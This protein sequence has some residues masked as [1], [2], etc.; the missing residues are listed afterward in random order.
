MSAAIRATGL[1]KHYGAVA[2]VDGLDLEVER[3]EIYGFLGRNGAGKS[4]TIRM[5]LGM[6]SPTAGRVEVLGEPV[7]A[8]GP[9]LWRR[10]GHLVESAT[11][12]GELSVR[13]NLEVARRLQGLTD[14]RR[15][16]VVIEQLALAP[17]ADRPAAKLSLG[18]VQRLALARALLHAPELLILDEPA[19]GLDPAGVVEVR[20]LL[21][22][23][24]RDH[25]VTVF[26]SSHHLTE[27]ERVA[28][29]VGVVHAGRM[30]MEVDAA[31]LHALRER[32]LEVGSRD[33]GAAA[34]ALVGLGLAPRRVGDV[35]ELREPRALDA[36]E[37][38]ARALVA[39]G[40]PPTRLVVVE[41][42]LEAHFLRLTEPRGAA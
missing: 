2:A 13:E 6:V 32:R 27:V 39:R 21:R 20:E 23:L 7:D 42:D 41:E 36:P 34:T 38:I 25:G 8:A 14:R 4:T 1:G 33:L 40:A 12:Y 18:N 26:M 24:A 28:T 22:S 16:D 15:V 31:G 19:N 30:V 9:S 35:L 11:A 17:Y 10:V 29:R 5:I 37:D 3:G